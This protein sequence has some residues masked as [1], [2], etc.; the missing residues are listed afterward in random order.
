MFEL[1]EQKVQR[2]GG[3]EELGEKKQQT[4]NQC[5]LD[6]GREKDKDGG[7]G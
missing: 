6:G 1:R 5:G 3:Q 4:E 2:R 7:G